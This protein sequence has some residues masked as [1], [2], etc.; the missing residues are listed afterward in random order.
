MRKKI[1]IIL[2]IALMIIFAT[3]ITYS[4]FNSNA[5]LTTTNQNIAKFI[6]DVEEENNIN[7]PLQNLIPGESEEYL[8]KVSSTSSDVSSDVNISYQIIIK[9][10]HFIPLDI[11]LYQEIDGDK[12]LVL[13]CDETYS[14]ND[15]NELVCNTPENELMYGEDYTHDYNLE[16]SFPAEYNDES[17]I[18]L[19][20]YLNLEIKSW[21]TL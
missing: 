15:G 19:V 13:T 8:F 1:I 18:G 9:T 3:G 5:S 21:Q 16:V 11:K 17:Y 6:F 7:L 14:R 12:V 2:G 10:Y 4:I 20:D